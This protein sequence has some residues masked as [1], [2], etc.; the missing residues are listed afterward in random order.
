MTS[1]TC[2][3]QPAALAVDQ[4]DNVWVTNSANNT[5]TQINANGQVVSL[6]LQRRRDCTA[7]SGLRLMAR[8]M[9]G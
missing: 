2:C 3:N 5:V 1:V 8:A 6:E 7:R 4:S 9:C